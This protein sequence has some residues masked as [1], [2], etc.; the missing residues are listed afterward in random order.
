MSIVRHVLSLIFV[1]SALL[2]F[3]DKEPAIDSVYKDS[4][5]NLEYRLE[6]LSYNFIN[7]EDLNERITSCYYF[8]QT[9]KEALMVPQS[10]NYTFK[11]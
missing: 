6:T 4:I 7:S 11:S 9:L 10:Y 5:R 3:A 8:I 1:G 2:A